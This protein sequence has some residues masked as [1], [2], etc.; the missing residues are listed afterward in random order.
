M[1]R[2]SEH[3]EREE[4]GEKARIS[5]N[6]KREGHKWREGRNEKEYGDRRENDLGTIDGTIVHM[7]AGYS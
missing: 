2:K 1:W 4:K 7:G 3:G 5:Q 6:T